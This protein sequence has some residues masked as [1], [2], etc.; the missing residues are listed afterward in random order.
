M[1]SSHSAAGNPN[2]N[3]LA[4][5]FINRM[6]ALEGSWKDISN[7]LN[8]LLLSDESKF[9]TLADNVTKLVQRVSADMEALDK[10]SGGGG[11]GR[12]AP[13]QQQQQQQQPA[14]FKSQ[15]KSQQPYFNQGNYDELVRNHQSQ[16]KDKYKEVQERQVQHYKKMQED[17]EIRKKEAQLR[18]LQKKT[19]KLEQQGYTLDSSSYERGRGQER[20]FPSPSQNQQQLQ[21]QSFGE[22]S[23]Q[24]LPPAHNPKTYKREPD[25][26]GEHYPNFD[27]KLYQ[28]ESAK[29]GRKLTSQEYRALPGRL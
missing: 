14:F 7:E 13:L 2:G 11:G 19:E 1:S 3:L 25:W 26:S 29:I 8:N 15:P 17:E 20:F 21:R 24:D 5:D 6:N 10:N 16:E 18:L 23:A 9:S 27:Q 4:T 12:A 22:F 28:R